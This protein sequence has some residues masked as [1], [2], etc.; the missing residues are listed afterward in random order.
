MTTL[1]PIQTI[2]N[3]ALVLPGDDWPTAAIQSLNENW[4]KS[5]AST[6][7]LYGAVQ[8]VPQRE[9]APFSALPYA[10]E[11]LYAY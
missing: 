8:E 6:L 9:S 3:V 2:A 1:R 10:M 5:H 7:E 11:K 4:A